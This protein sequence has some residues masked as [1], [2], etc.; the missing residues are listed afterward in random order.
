[1]AAHARLQ[2][3]LLC[4]R[5]LCVVR[6]LGRRERK[7]A[8]HDGKGIGRKRDKAP[9]FFLFPSIPA[10]QLCYFQWDTQREPR[11]RRDWRFSG[12]QFRPE[13]SPTVAVFS[14]CLLL[15]V[16]LFCGLKWVFILTEARKLNGLFSHDV[17]AARSGVDH[18]L[19][20][21]VHAFFAP[22]NLRR[23][24]PLDCKRSTEIHVVV[25]KLKRRLQD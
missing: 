13:T 6:R 10:R 19:F 18:E 22:I 2:C 23:C 8:G 17:T 14:G 24:W 1:M 9:A 25:L 15:L 5:P 3:S 20:S 4:Q 11:Q 7:R 21:F 12:P 16:V